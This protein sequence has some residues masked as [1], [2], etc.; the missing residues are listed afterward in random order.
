MQEVKTLHTFLCYIRYVC[1][2]T[3]VSLQKKGLPYFCFATLSY[4]TQPAE[5]DRS[6]LTHTLLVGGREGGR[7]EDGGGG[8][9]GGWCSFLPI[10]L[11]PPK[12]R[13]KNRKRKGKGTRFKSGKKLISSCYDE[14]FPLI[15]PYFEQ[16][17]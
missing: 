7:D 5:S 17:K 6:V 16:G 8:G 2:N 14:D 10:S 13:K 12:K 11:S 15:S 9:G 3:C 4:S 1:V